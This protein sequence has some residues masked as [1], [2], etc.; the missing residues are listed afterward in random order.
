MDTQS[1]SVRIFFTEW[2]KD[3][4]MEYVTCVSE[5]KSHIICTLIVYICCALW[6][7]NKL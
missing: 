4:G 1:A 5:K 2:K 7:Q 3:S 6:L